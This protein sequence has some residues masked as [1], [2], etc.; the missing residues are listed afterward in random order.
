MARFFLTDVDFGPSM[1]KLPSA[2]IRISHLRTFPLQD[3]EKPQRPSQTHHT[4]NQV[5][6]IL[7][8]MDAPVNATILEAEPLRSGC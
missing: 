5:S 7:R 4:P 8:R 1:P 3:T 2:D 6:Q